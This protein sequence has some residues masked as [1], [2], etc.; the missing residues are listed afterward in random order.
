MKKNI[1]ITA[2]FHQPAT[3]KDLVENIASC[4]TDMGY[5]KVAVPQEWKAVEISSTQIYVMGS[6]DVHTKTDSSVNQISMPFTSSFL[7]T[8]LKEKCGL[9]NLEWSLSLS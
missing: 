6:F 4:H 3:L 7:F 9:F 5:C 2:S 8:C 1:S